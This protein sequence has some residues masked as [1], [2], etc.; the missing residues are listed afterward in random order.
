MSVIEKLK[1]IDRRIIFVIIA[2]SVI[3]PLIAPL[4]LPVGVSPPVQA[5]YDYVESLPEGS[6]ILVAFDFDPGTMPE[7]YP[8]SIAFMRHC[9][10]KNHKIIAVSIWP[11]GA[12]LARDAFNQV[13]EQEYKKIYGIDFVNLGF[14]PGDVVAIK[15]LARSFKEIKPQDV[16][17]KPIGSYPIMQ[18]IDNFDNIDFVFELSAGFPG[19][20]EWVM[21]VYGRYKKPMASGCTAVSYPQYSPYYQSG[22]VKGLLGGLKAAAE[23]EVLIGMPAKAVAGMDAQSIAH[24]VI[25]FFVIIGNIFYFLDRKKRKSM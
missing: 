20:P 14:V 11:F 25:V 3:I 16:Y 19:I 4:N 21:I 7:L 8:M 22:Q 10:R 23:Y 2:L 18:G 15:A 9:F 1:S 6:T 24:A 13:G 5:T 12:P 17:G